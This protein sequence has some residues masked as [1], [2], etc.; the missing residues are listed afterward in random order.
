MGIV[1]AHLGQALKESG[2]D[3]E[4]IEAYQ[5]AIDRMWP[6]RD[7]TWAKKVLGE[8]LTELAVYHDDGGRVSRAV[9]C[10][11]KIVHLSPSE[12]QVNWALY[13]IGVSHRKMGN[14]E[15]MRQAFEDLN[16]RST[17][18]LWTKLATWTTGDLAFEDTAEPYLTGVTQAL[19]KEKKK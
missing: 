19:V 3:K 8:S 16:K 11:Q 6:F 2:R 10:Y 15:M 13:R 14:A 17:D 4:A 7:Q 1:F 12:D 18:S 5:E 9:E